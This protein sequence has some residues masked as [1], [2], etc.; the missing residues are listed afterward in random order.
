MECNLTSAALDTALG[1]RTDL[2][3]LKGKLA[4]GVDSN[5]IG[6]GVRGG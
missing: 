2:A 1:Q 4:E 5:L 3:P 6:L